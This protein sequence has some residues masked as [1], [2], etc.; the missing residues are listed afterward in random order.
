MDMTDVLATMLE[1]IGVKRYSDWIPVDQSMIDQFSDV[2]F[3]HQFIH[4]DPVRAARTAFGGT[5]AHGFLT[6]SLLP[7][8]VEPVRPTVPGIRIGVNYGF[9]RV[10]FVN[11]VRS[12]SQVRA[13]STITAVTE[14]APGQFQQV[15]EVV[16]EIRGVEK[17]ALT[18]TWLRQFIT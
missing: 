12:G 17:P 10:R 18:A 11:P 3:D 4:N 6:L 7:W 9:D 2:T 16:V 1:E 5:I 13:Q 14:K 8:L 15:C